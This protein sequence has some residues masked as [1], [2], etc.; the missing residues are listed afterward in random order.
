MSKNDYYDVLGVSKDSD[1]SSIKS[2]Y[3]KLAMEYHPDKNPG[4]KEAENKFKEISE[5]YEILSNPE[6][7]QAY[8]TY[9]HEAFSQGGAGF[10][11]GFSGFGSFSDIFE[12]FFGDFGGR[13]QQRREQRGQDLKYEIEIDLREAFTGIKKEISFDTLVR[14]Q[15][16]SGSGSEKGGTRK[17]FC[18]W[19]FWPYQSITGIFYC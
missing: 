4:D 6:K 9:G 2:A 13:P 12:D 8:D 1:P 11:E 18:M 17:L 16:C 3:R 7:K 19:R 10:S 15:D 5:A 14:C